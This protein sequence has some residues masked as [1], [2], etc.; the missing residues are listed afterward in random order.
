MLLLLVLLVAVDGSDV[1][2]DFFGDIFRMREC[3]NGSRCDNGGT[4]PALEI[5]GRPCFC[6]CAPTHLAYREDKQQC[7]KDIRECYMSVFYRPFTV[8]AI[9]LVY[10][11]TSGQLVHPDAHLSLAGRKNAEAGFPSCKAAVSQYLTRDGW[12][13]LTRVDGGGPVFGLF[14]DGNKTFLQFLGNSQDRRVLQQH[15]ALVRLFC[16]IPEYSPFE[17]CVAIRVGWVPGI[18]SMDDDPPSSKANMMVVG[19]SLGILGLVYVFAVLIY[20]RIRRQQIAKRKA[21]S[22]QEA[23]IPKRDDDSDKASTHT[24]IETSKRLELYHT[25][26]MGRRKIGSDPWSQ[27]SS[28]VETYNQTWTD[29]MG[30][31]GCEFKAQDFQLQPEFF[32]PE[33]MAS[34]PQQVLE[35]LERLQN[36]VTFARHRLR[37][38]YRYQPTL[39]GIPEDDYFY[40]ELEKV[41]TSPCKEKRTTPDGG[42]ASSMASLLEIDENPK[43]EKPKKEKTPPKIPPR[44]PQRKTVAKTKV[45]INHDALKSSEQEQKEI[46]NAMNTLNETLDALE[47]DIYKH[48]LMHQISDAEHTNPSRPSSRDDELDDFDTSSCSSLSAVTV[49]GRDN[50]KNMDMSSTGSRSVEKNLS[51]EF[52]T[53][54]NSTY[55]VG[56]VMP[57][58]F[59]QGNPPDDLGRSPD[60]SEGDGDCQ[61][62]ETEQAVNKD[63]NCHEDAPRSSPPPKDPTEATP[64]KF[65]NKLVTCTVKS[66]PPSVKNTIEKLN[67]LSTCSEESSAVES[68]TACSESSDASSVYSVKSSNTAYS[69]KP[70]KPSKTTADQ[71][72]GNYTAVSSTSTA[73]S[74][75]GEET[76][77]S[78]KQSNKCHG[79]K[80]SNVPSG[81]DQNDPSKKR[82]DKRH[83][84]IKS[85]ST[86]SMTTI[87]TD[88]TTDSLESCPS[89]PNLERSSLSPTPSLVDMWI[90]KLIQNSIPYSKSRRKFKKKLVLPENEVDN[91]EHVCQKHKDPCPM[92]DLK[93]VEP[94]LIDK[95][96]HYSSKTMAGK[97]VAGYF[98]SLRQDVLK[99]H[100]KSWLLTNGQVKKHKKGISVKYRSKESSHKK[101]LVPVS[102]D[103]NSVCEPVPNTTWTTF[104]KNPNGTTAKDHKSS[105]NGHSS[106]NS[107]TELIDS[108]DSENTNEMSNGSDSNDSVQVS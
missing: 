70:S 97:D 26:S 67:A 25:T 43:E 107:T 108:L 45:E 86:E 101:P 63:H 88:M 48:D 77:P 103:T 16:K 100:L 22:D 61:N 69:V 93:D 76:K 10:L 99:E 73:T 8:E 37:S 78:I 65:P 30:Q 81:S 75:S 52:S 50:R 12:R 2:R 90:S 71:S 28:I 15:L 42:S 41:R 80:R 98:Q 9:P 18:D 94:N 89:S 60:G 39:I 38:C 29:R 58:L 51:E 1:T 68:S 85:S 102:Q 46:Q 66:F 47:Y 31:H 62:K 96:A 92:H 11:P 21:N 106:I 84:L 17:T 55:S 40:Q 27:M 57:G 64:S 36:S 79:H 44:K 20:L 33:F 59:A 54:R 87:S 83:L 95:L 7:V 104:N 19:L 91:W 35:Y 6:Q 23:C 4:R 56:S 82:S 3:H 32:D 24:R 5:P 53:F 49:L 74:P 72:S 14:A 13:T 34:P 105:S